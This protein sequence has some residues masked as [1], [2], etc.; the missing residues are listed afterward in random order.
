MA[1]D[2]PGDTPGEYDVIVLGLGGMGSAAVRHLARRG[3]R[4]LG[5]EQFTPA[6]ALGSSHG[7]TRIVRM[8][9]F[10]APDYVPLLRRAYELWDELAADTGR[11]LFVRAG[12]LMIGAPDSEVVRGTL[13]SVERYDLPHE[14]LDRAAMARRFPQF[15]LRAGEQAVFERNAGFV[16]P[17]VVVRAHLDLAAR[18]GAELRFETPVTSWRAGAGGVVVHTAGGDFAGRRLV[19]AAGAWAD[20]VVSGLGVP[21]RVA[22]RVMHYLQPVA[23]AADFAVDRFP[24]YVYETGARDAIYGF[25]WVDDP[26]EGVKA[27]FHYR[28]GDVDPDT[29]DREV[30]PAER[31]EMRAAL[32]ERIPGLAGAHLATKVC[33][34]TLTPDEHFVIEHLPGQ[35][36]RVIVAAGFSG[37]GFKFTPVVGEI[38]ADLALIGHTDLP[39]GFLSGDRFRDS[40]VNTLAPSRE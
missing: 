33:M 6:H 18:D 11:E 15:A 30:S 29:V 22:R 24:V 35:H 8:A 25:P 1:A 40:S 14:L 23:S 17:E 36:A 12:A 5:L 3:A 28:G 39:I 7:D 9:Y 34:Y 19:I 13:A 38:L 16:N 20:R 31:E 32:A 26:G 37:H 2:L 4:V 21:L 27:G 10:E